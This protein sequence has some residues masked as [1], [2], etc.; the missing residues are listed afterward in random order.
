MKNKEMTEK[1]IEN[2]V[3]VEKLRNGPND[4]VFA[5]PFLTEHNKIIR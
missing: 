1:I 2:L 5:E 3:A 4:L